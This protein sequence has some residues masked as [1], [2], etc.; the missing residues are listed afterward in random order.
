MDFGGWNT[1][2]F[3]HAFACVWV[4]VRVCACLCI[5]SEREKEIEREGKGMSTVP[6]ERSRSLSPLNIFTSSIYAHTHTAPIIMPL[7]QIYNQRGNVPS[8]PPCH[9]PAGI[10]IGKLIQGLAGAVGWCPRA[11]AEQGDGGGWGGVKRWHKSMSDTEREKE[12][13]GDRKIKQRA[14]IWC[15]RQEDKVMLRVDWKEDSETEWREDRCISVSFLVCDTLLKVLQP[16]F[17]PSPP[18]SSLPSLQSS[19][20]HRRGSLSSG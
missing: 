7:N 10:G 18:S 14:E 15:Q 5:K 6:Q 19:P 9:N 17:T 3:A 16:R 12:R 20:F 8:S 1:H 2:V 4:C 11:L 13:A